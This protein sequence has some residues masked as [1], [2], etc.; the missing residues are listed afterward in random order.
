[1]SLLKTETK[2]RSDLGRYNRIESE[3]KRPQ[4][5][6]S[7]LRNRHRCAS[8]KDKTKASYW[9]ICNLPRY[10]KSLGLGNGGNFFW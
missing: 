3:T 4:S 1:M 8:Q 5:L 10:A 7:P 9:G 6:E 2:L